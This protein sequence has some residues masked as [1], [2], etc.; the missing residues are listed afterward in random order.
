MIEKEAGANEYMN[1]ESP[2]NRNISDYRDNDKHVKAS[3]GSDTQPNVHEV[4]ANALKH[5]R[6]FSLSWKYL[7]WYAHFVCYWTPIP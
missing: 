6:S 1:F 3:L 7:E 2:Q 4:I 5:P